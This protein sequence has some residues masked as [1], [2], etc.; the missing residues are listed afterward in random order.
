LW[1]LDGLR[2]GAGETTRLRVATFD[3]QELRPDVIGEGIDFAGRRG[4]RDCL[5]Q[6]PQP[7]RGE[8]LVAIEIGDQLVAV[9]AD[10]EI[11][12]SGAEPGFADEASTGVLRLVFRSSTAV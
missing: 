3:Q 11:V 7:T 6:R 2:E 12:D 10:V 9:D 1:R 4:G 5:G 8:R